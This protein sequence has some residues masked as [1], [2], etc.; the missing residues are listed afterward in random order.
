MIEIYIKYVCDI[1]VN[2]IVFDLIFLLYKNFL[3]IVLVF[4]CVEFCLIKYW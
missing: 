4:V 2:D 3:N 1:S